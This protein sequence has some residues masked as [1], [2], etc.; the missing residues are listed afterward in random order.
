[1][2]ERRRRGG[3]RGEL[4]GRENLRSA[5]LRRVV[6]EDA[7]RRWTTR[8]PAARGQ[9]GLSQ[10][11]QTS[12]RK[13]SPEALYS[14]STASPR[15]VDPC[16]SVT[17]NIRLVR[18]TP[19]FGEKPLLLTRISR[20]AAYSLPPA[21]AARARP[22]GGRRRRGP[23]VGGV[24]V[25]Y[26]GPDP[27]T[28]PARERLRTHAPAGTDAYPQQR[29]HKPRSH[30]T[31]RTSQIISLRAPTEV[32]V[33]RGTMT[34]D[35]TCLVHLPVPTSRF[36]YRLLSTSRSSSVVSW[37]RGSCSPVPCRDE[38][39]RRAR[40]GDGA[41][42][43]FAAVTILRI[44]DREQDR[45]SGEDAS[46]V[47]CGV[48]ECVTTSLRRAAACPSGRVWCGRGRAGRDVARRA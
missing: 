31:R 1:M 7:I 9:R 22:R 23:P 45:L 30:E 27:A 19:T 16:R 24:A 25:P 14:C 5:R 34:K 43:G 10:S 33:E 3:R 39:S 44:A 8:L 11:R 32:S 42:G 17:R 18:Q 41:A 15:H 40:F 29:D 13:S 28:C 46:G 21:T 26:Q 20:C 48:G 12:L 6:R 2:Y 4:E 47:S 35:K 38:E 37:F 36:L